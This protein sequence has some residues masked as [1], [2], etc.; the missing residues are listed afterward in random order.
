MKSAASEQPWRTT[1]EGLV[2]RVR[3]T[4]KSGRDEIAG[5]ETTAEGAALKARV[6]ALPSEGEAN[7]ALARLLAAWLG[8][9]KSSVTLVS[10][11]KSRIKSLAIRGEPNLLAREID[12]KLA[13]QHTG[14]TA[15]AER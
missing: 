3:V 1:A 7:A 13:R 15:G 9:P 4:P 10:G 8:V 12:T 14:A 11:A 2:V 5:I 6:R